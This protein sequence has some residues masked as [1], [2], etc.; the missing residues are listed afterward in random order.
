MRQ[1]T[2]AYFSHCVSDLNLCLIVAEDGYE[3][4]IVSLDNKQ[5]HFE[6]PTVEV[7]SGVICV[8]KI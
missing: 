1:V 6:A 5:W 4:I 2:E 8:L 7:S 3:F